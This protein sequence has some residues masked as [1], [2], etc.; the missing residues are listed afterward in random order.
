MPIYTEFDSVLSK[1][2]YGSTIF[3]YVKIHVFHF[4]MV[5]YV[6]NTQFLYNIPRLAFLHIIHGQ[7]FEYLSIL[8]QGHLRG[9]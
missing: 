5:L 4:D 9:K 3:M 1:E 2:T 6:Y 8:A 7:R